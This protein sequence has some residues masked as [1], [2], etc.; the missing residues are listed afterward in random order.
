[1]SEKLDE[2]KNEAITLG[3][4]FSP[5]IGEAK[6][7]GKIDDYY[8]E[9]AASNSAPVE[10][11]EEEVE[12]APEPV[13]TSAKGGTAK[14]RTVEQIKRDAVARGKKIMADSIRA[15]KR[16]EI[17]KLTMVDKREASTATDAYFNNGNTAMRVPL[18]V[19]V[20]IPKGLIRMAESAKALIHMT[21]EKGTF[22]KLTKKYVV[23]YKR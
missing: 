19:F 4:S 3:I 5:N 6:L 2:L 16:T 15:D 13:V 12:A 10:V 11:I 17:V 8:A 14:P 21:G 20:E 18:D 7:Q 23:E 22:S 1:M 9:E